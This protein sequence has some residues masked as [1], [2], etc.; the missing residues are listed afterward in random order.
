MS[1]EN[2]QE[3]LDPMMTWERKANAFFKP[4]DMSVLRY[5][6]LMGHKFTGIYTND[7]GDRLKAGESDL[8]ED[9][10]QFLDGLD[11]PTIYERGKKCWYLLVRKKPA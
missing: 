5:S 8:F 11:E 9:V 3:A 10:Q 6:G 2:E 4:E 7:E 1:E